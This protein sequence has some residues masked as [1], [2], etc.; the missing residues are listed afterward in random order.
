MVFPIGV[1]KH[2]EPYNVK[3]V[4]FFQELLRANF[5]KILISVESVN[6]ILGTVFFFTD[7]GFMNHVRFRSIECS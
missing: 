7:L 2:F 3:G 1:K 4:C 5:P 6:N